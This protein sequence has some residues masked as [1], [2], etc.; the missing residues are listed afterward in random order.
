MLV[1]RLFVF[2]TCGANITIVIEDTTRLEYKHQS[3]A[4][5]ESLADCLGIMLK[6]WKLQQRDPNT[7]NWVIG[8]GMDYPYSNGIRSLKSPENYCQPRHMDE[9]DE[10]G[11]EDNSGVHHNSGIPNRAFYLAATKIGHPSWETVGTIWYKS[12][13]DKQQVTPKATFEAFAEVTIYHSPVEF[14]SQVRAAWEEVGVNTP[15]LDI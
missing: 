11:G 5:N 9:Y 1:S 6:H 13:T 3:G 8:S 14:K 2:S 12:M 15:A 10:L 7:A 4:L